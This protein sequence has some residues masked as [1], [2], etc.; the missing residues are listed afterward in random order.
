MGK[1]SNIGYIAQDCRW[2]V[3]VTYQ[4]TED[5]TRSVVHDIME[6][7]ELQDLIEQGPT[8]CSII[9]FTIKY[10]GSVETIKESYEL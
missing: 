10:C 7:V 3:N 4:V 5:E 9:D 6:L 2:R 1:I 8:F